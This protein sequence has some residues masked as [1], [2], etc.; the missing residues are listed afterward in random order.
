MVTAKLATSYAA[1]RMDEVGPVEVFK[2]V[3]VWV[4]GVRTTIEIVGR[5]VFPTFLVTCILWSNSVHVLGRAPKD[6]RGNPPH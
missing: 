1:D 3:L 2:P 5:R 6:L 4:V